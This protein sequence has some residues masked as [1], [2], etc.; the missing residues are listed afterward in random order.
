L[1]GRILATFAQIPTNSHETLSG[2][3]PTGEACQGHSCQICIGSGDVFS[4]RR[5]FD[6][7]II[8][9]ADFT[10]VTLA[11]SLFSLGELWLSRALLTL[12][13]HELAF[14]IDE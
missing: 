14:A 4:F 8:A 3:G 13:M 7:K 12:R 1:W 6:T 5:L 11:L 9:N 10:S 2:E